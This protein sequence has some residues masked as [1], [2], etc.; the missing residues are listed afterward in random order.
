M[1]SRFSGRLKLEDEDGSRVLLDAKYKS[2][3]GQR[4]PA[5]SDLYQM[6]AY[7]TAGTQPYGTVA[8]LYPSMRSI[9]RRYRPEAATVHSAPSTRSFSTTGLQTGLTGSA[10]RTP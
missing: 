9:A 10:R 1:P 8:L 7:A 3:H 2:L 5:Q 6:H 4:S